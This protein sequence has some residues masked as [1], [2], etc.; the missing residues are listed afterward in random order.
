MTLKNLNDTID[1]QLKFS[2]VE[3]KDGEVDGVNILAKIRGQFFV[4]NGISRNDRYYPI[5]LWEKVIADEDIQRRIKK[6]LMFGTV[7]HDGEV[8]EKA[9]RE[10]TVSHVVTKIWIDE[11]G[12]GMGEALIF[13]TKAGKNLNIVLRGGA[14]LYVSSRA[15]GTY[16]GQ[17]KGL[18]IVDSETYLLEGWDFVVD[19]GFL[20]AHPGIAE[21]FNKIHNI[22]EGVNNMAE[23][24]NN[25]DVTMNEEL[26]KHITS[27]NAD[28]KNSVKNLTDE[29]VAL[30]EDKQVIDDENT[31]LKTENGKLEEATKK[32]GA[33]EKLCKF[34]DLEETIKK[35]SED[36]TVL[37]EFLELADNPE[38]TKKCLED[39]RDLL[40][41]Y[42][43]IGS[44][45]DIKESLEKA[46]KFVDEV[47]ALGK[48]SEIK[49]SLEAFK[50]QLDKES[51]ERDIKDNA[52]LVEELGLTEEKVIE[53]RKKFSA[54][55]IK[56]MYSALSENADDS[57]RFKKRKLDEDNNNNNN[58][59]DG[60]RPS[61]IAR[62]NERLKS[63]R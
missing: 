6:R 42:K 28:L 18:P 15:D 8:N 10:G 17:H 37:A 40:V 23:N 45:E 5:E 12:R 27:E 48:L 53:L 44:I 38:E 9:I 22:K 46:D 50:E 30:K 26:I 2:L 24:A 32:I 49:T 35:I 56:D 20:D 52:Q 61:R 1:P 33:F 31:H 34:E 58:A 16:K 39:L 43:E 47:N 7:G 36:K 41:E 25:K 14:E 3:G 63:K 62:L 54:E 59:N 57:D 55:D 60:V 29:I 4:P 51:S 19:P 13:N 21:S 11:K